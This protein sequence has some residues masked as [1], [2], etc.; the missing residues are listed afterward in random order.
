MT[1]AA[2][3]DDLALPASRVYAT[4]D[5]MLRYVDEG[6]GPAVVCVHGNPTWSFH[7]RRLLRALSTDHR[8]IVPDHLGMGRSD[9]P[10]ERHYGFD[11]AAR[12][13]DFSDLM[14][15]VGVGI[16][17]PATLVVHDWGGAIALAW[18]TRQPHRVGRLVVLNTA[19]FPVPDRLRF[20]WLLRPFRVPCLGEV[21]VCGLNAFVRG[22][23]WIGA[24]RQRLPAPVR[25]AYRAP[26]DS[27]HRRTAVLRFVRDVPA[28]PRGPTH[29]L[30]A[31]T[32]A[33]LHRLADRPTLIVWGMRDPV[34]GPPILDEWRR[35][36]PAAEVHAIG[37][38]GHLVLEDAPE[39]VPMIAAFL[40]R[41]RWTVDHP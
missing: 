5:G 31:E 24:R 10:S 8:V 32:D 34:L 17:R 2:A 3:G 30:L 11:L 41:T 40:A 4:A 12:V 25:R 28:A 22:T 33:E 27:W 39:T 37:D 18:A 20:P 26:Y 23:L 29:A 36:L 9:M 13:A 35:R 21:L 6:T 14:D 38:A 7:Y 16:S 1:S 15:H 19:V